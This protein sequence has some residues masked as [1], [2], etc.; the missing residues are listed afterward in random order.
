MSIEYMSKIFLLSCHLFHTTTG[1]QELPDSYTEEMSDCPKLCKLC[2][3]L[4]IISSNVFLDEKPT[5]YDVLIKLA[6]IDAKWRSIGNGL[7]VEYNVLQGLAESNMSNQDKL[8]HVLQTWIKMDGHDQH[9]PVNWTTIMDVVKGPLIKNYVL[10]NEIYQY[11]KQESS[12][13][14]KA[15]SK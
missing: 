4:M 14:Q 12:E 13:H 9:T 2:H 15:T 5:K 6:P 10:A 1:H 8:S 7:R 3:H 11:L